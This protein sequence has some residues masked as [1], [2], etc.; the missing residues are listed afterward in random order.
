MAVCNSFEA[1]ATRLHSLSTPI[2]CCLICRVHTTAARSNAFRSRWVCTL[3]DDFQMQH[4][5]A[6]EMNDFRVEENL[7]AACKRGRRARA[8]TVRLA[9]PPPPPGRLKTP[10][11]I[12][13]LTVMASLLRAKM[14]GEDR[15]I[16]T[17]L[18]HVLDSSCKRA[19]A[20]R[21]GSPSPAIPAEDVLSLP[22]TPS[23]LP[24]FLQSCGVDEAIGYRPL[25][26]SLIAP[27]CRS[28]PRGQLLRQVTTEQRRRG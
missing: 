3:W 8:R 14:A 10:A 15:H 26:Q 28:P 9:A 19:G 22:A 13:T 21:P 18:K 2:G 17:S 25:R 27:C 24:V 7:A 6:P 1:L 20:P 5:Y 12:W 16:R 4:W 11:R 23:S